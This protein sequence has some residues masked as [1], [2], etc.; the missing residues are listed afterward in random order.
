M[1]LHEMSGNALD[2]HDYQ[3]PEAPPPP[4]LPPP[5][6]KLPLSLDD[7]P[8]L[9]LPPD[10]EP[11]D[12]EPPRDGP[13]DFG[14]RS[15]MNARTETDEPDDHGN[16]DGS[17]KEQRQNT[18][19]AAG[20]DRAQQ[21]PQQGAQDSADD[22][23]GKQRDRDDRSDVFQIA[24]VHAARGNRQGLTVDDANHA[25]DTIRDATGEVSGL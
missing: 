19:Q 4:K 20:R 14:K 6:L 15:A 12:Q 21:L 7:D 22:E 3:L 24:E 16:A 11:L 10:E 18:D 25:I 1:M 9:Q 17:D 5:P 8:L 13:V 2:A 23:R